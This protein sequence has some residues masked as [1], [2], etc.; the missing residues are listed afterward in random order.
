[1][2]QVLHSVLSNGMRGKILI[3]NNTNNGDFPSFFLF[4]LALAFI[5]QVEEGFVFANRKM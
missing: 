1:M 5:P 3:T 2:I 4:V